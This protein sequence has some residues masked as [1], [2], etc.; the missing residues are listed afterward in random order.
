MSALKVLACVQWDASTETCLA[1]AYID[2]PTVIPTLTAEQGAAIGV[3]LLGCYVV[4]KAVGMLREAITDR[5][6]S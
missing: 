4:V 5:I 2:P 1:Q 3:K 6:G